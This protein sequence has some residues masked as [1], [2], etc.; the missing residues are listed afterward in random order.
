MKREP[1][2]LV[3]RSRPQSAPSLPV[4]SLFSGA[5]GLDLGFTKAGFKPVL[6]VD[7][8]PA[9]CRTYQLNHRGCHVIRRDLS[10]VSAKYI[11]QRLAE[12]PEDVKPVGVI[13]GPPCQA[14]SPGN[15]FKRRADPR[16]NLPR[17]YARILTALTKSLHIDFFVFENVLGLRYRENEKLFRHF[18]SLF[19]RAGFNIFEG[20]L[21][22][23]DF[24]VPQHRKRV[25]I[26]GFNRAKYSDVEFSFPRVR[27]TLWRTVRD[28]IQGLPRPV[29]FDR[30]LKPGIIPFHV[31]HWC[32][33]PRSK[34]FFNGF[35]KGKGGQ[36]KGRPFRVLSWGKPSWTVAY[37]H[38][39]VHVHPS[40]RRRLSVYEAMLLQGLPSWYRLAGNLSEQIRLVSDVVPPNL[41]EAIARQ[42]WRVLISLKFKHGRRMSGRQR[43]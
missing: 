32:M 24:R 34:K 2:R 42:I 20:C 19:R 30:S 31:N 11:L 43:V 35:L 17:S 28:A 38:R 41:G 14:F 9:A 15:R 16:A 8:D 27:S 13:G 10:D 21:D 1:G 7:V 37:G 25:F 12:L 39:E 33:R 18:K 4:I 26:V 29:F 3:Q 6:A 22:A 36:T 23:K 40:G 5:G